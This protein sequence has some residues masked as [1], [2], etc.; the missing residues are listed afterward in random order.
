MVPAGFDTV[1]TG[2]N[3]YDRRL[4]T[5]L[6]DAGA[7]VGV[8]AVAGTWP[9]PDQSAEQ[10][11]AQS[12]QGVA[13]PILVDGLVAAG[14]P[15]VIEDAVRAGADVRVLVHMPLALDPALDADT[16]ARLDTLERRT[17]HAARGVICTS[18]W[19]ADE[20]RRRHHIEAAIAE[21][22]TVPAAAAVGSVPP[23]IVQVGA[24]SD[25]KN[26]LATVT[27]LTRLT[28][29]DWTAR[30]IGPVGDSS[31]A[32][33]VEEAIRD[34]GLEERIRLTGQ[35]DGPELE[36]QWDTAD[37]SVLPSKTETYGMVVAESLAHAVPAVVSAGT[38]AVHTLGRDSAGKRPGFVVAVVDTDA[39]GQLAAVLAD[40]LQDADIRRRVKAAAAGRRAMLTR[41]EST[42]AAV[43]R[44]LR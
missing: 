6:R 17:L 42:A 43:L 16:A 21:P 32:A 44:T 14:C 28:G 19:A 23:R 39:P 2:G 11:L 33:T 38:G 37:I 5:A 24:I 35:L 8:V 36:H 22:G 26:Q 41:W 30:L 10:Q 13:G 15:R 3:I 12:L 1:V 29:F 40:W 34:A 25:L 27:A 9:W 18:S 7:D 31:Y 4:L 20:L